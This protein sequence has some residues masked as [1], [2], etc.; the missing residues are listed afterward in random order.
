MQLDRAKDAKRHRDLRERASTSHRIS[1]CS[2]NSGPL[3]LVDGQSAYKFLA[4]LGFDSFTVSWTLNP[5]A[6]NGT[7]VSELLSP[8]VR[9]LTLH[10]HT[11]QRMLAHV[12]VI[13]IVPCALC[14]VLCVVCIVK[15]VAFW[16]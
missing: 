16:C 14:H 2:A 6:D 3:P 10:E 1:L 11:P 15:C 8:S 7:P 13:V 12:P 9:S 4:K 5:P